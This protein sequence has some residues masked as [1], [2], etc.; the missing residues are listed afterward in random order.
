MRDAMGADDGGLAPDARSARCR[1]DKWLWC[2]R[3]YKTRSMA[4]QAICAGRAHLNAERVK[5][6]HAVRVGDVVSVVQDGVVAEFN[7]IALPARRGSAAQS[8]GHFAETPASCERRERLR[9][10]HRL[11]NLSRP[12]SEERPDKRD[13]RILLKLQRGQQ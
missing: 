4:Q 5:P 6:S 1:L 3:F 13:R 7:V 2:T 9:E 11:A 12:R 8:R 10:Q